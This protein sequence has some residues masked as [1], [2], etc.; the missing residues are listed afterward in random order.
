M[1]S[2]IKIGWAEVDITPKEKIIVSG[3]F[4]E[5]I[6]DEIETP[7]TVTALAIESNGE[8]A[9]ICSCDIAC[10][11][12]ELL[13]TVRKKL[14]ENELG[15]DVTKIILGATHTHTSYEYDCRDVPETASTIEILKRY[16]PKGK[17]YIVHTSGEAMHPFDAFDILVEKL[18]IAIRTAWENRDYGYYSNAFGRAAVGMCR[19]VAYDDGSAK[20]WGD[21]NMANFSELEG[22][23]D[24]GIE[25]LYFFDANKNITGILANIACPAQVLEQRSI[26][27]SDYWG[28][29]KILLREHFGKNLF[30]LGMTSPAGDQCP[31]D[32][33]RWVDPETPIDDPNVA[34]R[35]LSRS[36][37]PSM[38]D[39]KGTWKIGRR[40]FH[41]IV[42][43]YEEAT[44]KL[45]GD[46]M[47]IHRIETLYLPLRR[48]TINEYNEAEEKLHNY[49]RE[50]EGDIDYNDNAQLYVYAGTI[51]RYEEQQTKNIVSVELHTIRLGEV[52][53]ANNPFELFLD[54]AN[55]IRAR[56]YSNQTFL[57][58]MS[59]GNMG[60]LPTEKAEKAGHYSAYISS[61][62]VGHEG[63]DLLV[64]KTLESINKMF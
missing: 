56:S 64:R 35:K 8:Q 13:E 22:G 6:S 9:V 40:I 37:D 44:E 54:Y 29:V 48:A 49:F 63:G 60:Y 10:I 39:I 20:M 59:N 18:T 1:E 36:A 16:I 30:V 15:L 55:R 51:I 7:I 17:K 3:Q 27:S 32:L 31:R 46:G 43:V 5:R 21:S 28:K 23:N 61:G 25:L 12:E 33:I 14:S 50:C 47:F 57:F 38:Y 26:I 53:F 24:S 42:D 11:K 41:E 19:R 45:K 58:Q 34:P 52:A 2:K 4:Y 62:K